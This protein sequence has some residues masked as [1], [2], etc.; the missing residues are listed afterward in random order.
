MRKIFFLSLSLSLMYSGIAQT[1]EAAIK[2]LDEVSE[3]IA[4]FENLSFDFSY[5]LENRQENIK[6]ETS[7]TVT[8]E[9]DRYKLMYLGA[10]QLF[11]GEKTYTVVPEN[12]EITVS[13][14]EDGEDFGINPSELLNFY[15][16]GYDY[17]WD[18]KQN[19]FGRPIQFVKLIP[20]DENKEVSYLLLGVDVLKK[21]IY[22]LIEI[23]SNG[24]RTTL[25]LSNQLT[26]ISLAQD[27]FTF[28]VS[29]YPDYYIN[30]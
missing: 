27:F 10:E 12:E 28:D 5:T 3:T 26:N 13:N 1:S 16:E 9:G 4:A 25:T 7:G 24:T 22:R 21:T 15:K 2:L 18:I 17:Q 11:D 29:R 20:S 14:P 23:G 6:Q 30:N 19:I 8:V